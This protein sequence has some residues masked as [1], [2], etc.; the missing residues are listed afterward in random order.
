MIARGL[1]PLTGW[2]IEVDA[3]DLVLTAPDDTVRRLA[4]GSGS[5]QVARVCLVTTP[6]WPIWWLGWGPARWCDL[7]LTQTAGQPLAV[8]PA[9]GG[10]AETAR[11]ARR[12]AYPFYPSQEHVPRLIPGWSRAEVEAVAASSGLAVDERENRSGRRI[13]TSLS[14]V[15]ATWA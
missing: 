14:D 2:L 12:F 10:W 15:K 3:D 9:G 6:V 5:G 11:T 4:T 1:G 13:V 7:H 8:L